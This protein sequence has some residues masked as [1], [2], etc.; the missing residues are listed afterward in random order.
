MTIANALNILKT[1]PN[2]DIDKAG[3]TLR[4]NLKTEDA[5]VDFINSYLVA[6]GKIT[7]VPKSLNGNSPVRNEVDFIDLDSS[8]IEKPQS[9]LNGFG[10]LPPM[11]MGNDGFYKI[12][13]EQT[14]AE[15]SDL[16]RRYDDA[17]DDKHKAEIELVANRSGVG[18]QLVQGVTALAPT[19]AGIFGGGGMAGVGSTETP[20]QQIQA[21]EVKK[22]AQDPKL[23]A[24]VQH[25]GTLDEETKTKVYNLLAKVFA[26]PTLLDELLTQL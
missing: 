11:P 12:L 21:Q 1:Y 23:V 2:F 7:L 3:V 19:L 5:T 20:Q 18:A 15:L 24:I 26:T 16:K 14:R 25:Y 9:A 17:K 6:H 4:K 13:Y 10:E 8:M 22:Q